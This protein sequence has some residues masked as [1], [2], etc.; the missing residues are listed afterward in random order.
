MGNIPVTR[1]SPEVVAGE[2]RF[3]QGDIFRL[4]LE[5]ELWDQDGVPVTLAQEDTV[6]LEV[7][8][9]TE[10]IIL[11]ETFTGLTGNTLEF[12]MD[13]SKTALFS[14]GEYNW[15][16]RVTH[17]EGLTTIVWGNKIVVR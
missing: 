1:M 16:L 10:E 6:I 17:G 3:C 4:R 12:R 14:P 15:R 11:A 2:L 5:L 8:D 9:R 13:G 7:R